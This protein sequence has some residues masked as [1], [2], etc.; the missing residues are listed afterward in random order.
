MLVK[1][2]MHNFMGLY[3]SIFGISLEATLYKLV[4]RFSNCILMMPSRKA[5]YKVLY[6]D[7]IGTY[8]IVFN[9]KRIL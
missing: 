4:S 2:L 1:A 8:F 9:Y 6:E 5:T 7:L 3:Y